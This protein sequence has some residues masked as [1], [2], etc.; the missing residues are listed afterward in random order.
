M[1]IPF[2]P[3]IVTRITDCCNWIKPLAI[4]TLIIAVGAV[5]A[6]IFLGQIFVAIGFA[7]LG[8]MSLLLIIEDTSAMTKMEQLQTQIGQTNLTLQQSQQSETALSAKLTEQEQKWASNVQKMQRERVQF[9]ADQAQ[10]SQARGDFAQEQQKLRVEIEA[11]KQAEWQLATADAVFKDFEQALKIHAEQVLALEV[12]AKII[13]AASSALTAKGAEVN[14]ALAAISKKAMG[15]PEQMKGWEIT[16]N[17][18]SGYL[19]AQQKELQK[20]LETATEKLETD[21]KTLQALNGDLEKRRLSLQAE[22]ERLEKTISVLQEETK[23]N[24]EAADKLTQTMLLAAKALST[25]T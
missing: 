21:Q 15:I 9:E 10:F 16:L 7:L 8:A 12:P 11:L 3:T 18:L 1:I 6:S 5:A 20:Q 22:Q 25:S 24:T 4:T 2:T 14:E 23:K 13:E 17:R 19:V